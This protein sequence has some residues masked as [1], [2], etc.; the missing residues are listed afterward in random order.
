MSEGSPPNRSRTRRAGWSLG[1]E[2]FINRSWVQADFPWW[3]SS[4]NPPAVWRSG[5]NPGAG[6]IPRRRK[7]HPTPVFL[8][9]KSH[10]QRSLEGNSPW[11][12]HTQVD[13]PPG[14][15]LSPTEAG[16]GARG[17]RPGR[18]APSKKQ[19]PSL[20]PTLP[21][22]LTD[23]CEATAPGPKTSV[24]KAQPFLDST[25]CPAA[26]ITSDENAVSDG[27]RSC[28]LPRRVGA[29]WGSPRKTSG[30]SKSLFCCQ[31][32]QGSEGGSD[33]PKVPS[34]GQRLAP[35]CCSSSVLRIL[36][37]LKDFQGLSVFS[38]LVSLRGFR[39][40]GR[41]LAGAQAALSRQSHEAP[42]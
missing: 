39:A 18:E 29:L 5:F 23:L 8:P 15:G 21:L 20:S 1:P 40:R 7:W 36:Q 12:E 14:Q 28:H 6:K 9:G 26:N 10:G 11:G 19:G 24:L 31:D 2:R 37:G 42:G 27:G 35:P 34:C 16:R 13:Q 41:H 33:F 22:G 3:L 38:A 25:S 4:K 32:D 30:L 17:G